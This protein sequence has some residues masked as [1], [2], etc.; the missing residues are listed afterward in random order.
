MNDK[1]LK[2]RA[3]EYAINTICETCNQCQSKGYIGCDK[4]RVGKQAYIAGAIEYK[5]SRDYAHNAN[6]SLIKQL[7]EA[8]EIIKE[9]LFT[10]NELDENT[11]ELAEQFLGDEK[12]QK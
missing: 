10:S 11:R 9:L 3:E 12:C 5:Q 1:L 2:Q 8:K 7:E 6:V 4:Y